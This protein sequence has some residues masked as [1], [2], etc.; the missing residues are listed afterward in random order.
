MFLIIFLGKKNGCAE[1]EE[2]NSDGTFVCDDDGHKVV[3]CTC[4]PFFCMRW[5]L[6]RSKKTI[7][8]IQLTITGIKLEYDKS[9]H[10]KM[11]KKHTK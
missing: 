4:S 11:Q 1:V 2:N 7:L 5:V 9:P 8:K 6:L 10:K 3:L